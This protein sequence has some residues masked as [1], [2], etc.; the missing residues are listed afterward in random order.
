MPHRVTPALAHLD[1]PMCL[2]AR[3]ASHWGA[4]HPGNLLLQTG[5]QL[6]AHGAALAAGLKGSK[7]TSVRVRVG[8][9]V[10]AN[11]NPNP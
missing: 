10:R 4:Y 11:P 3:L 9:G 7:V 6:L 8:V 5:E 1:V 2:H